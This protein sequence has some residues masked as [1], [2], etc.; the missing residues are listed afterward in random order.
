MYNTRCIRA[1][2][3]GCINPYHQVI[4]FD[5]WPEERY[6]G[7]ADH[8]MYKIAVYVGILSVAVSIGSI[9]VMVTGWW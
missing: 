9:L 1:C 4:E 8:K 7:E 6:L 2:I 5:E 3:G